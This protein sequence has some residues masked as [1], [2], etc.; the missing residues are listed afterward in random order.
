MSLTMADVL[1]AQYR[2]RR[3]E[4]EAMRS[5]SA[6]L[7][8]DIQQ[9]ASADYL[10][11]NAVAAGLPEDEVTA[12]LADF[13]R[14]FDAAV[15]NC[16]QL[17]GAARTAGIT[18]VH[19]RIEALAGDARDT[20]A[21]H[22]RMGWK[23]PPGSAASQFLAAVAPTPGEIVVSK[24]CS[25]AFTSTALDPVLRNMGIRHL[26]ICGF[27]TDECIEASTRA[28]L[29]LGYLTRVVGDA[30]TTYDE[31]SWAAVTN[32]YASFGI[33]TSTRRVVDRFKTM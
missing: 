6:L 31:A 32:K 33:L 7:L 24:T 5:D 8:I 3:P 23:Y 17:L 27:M 14:R 10:H 13:R 30:T 28:A 4:P 1:A 9:L 18:P 15:V 25:G 20:G 21:V 22:A 29:D 26:W 19:V 2:V 16:A 12:A 11:T